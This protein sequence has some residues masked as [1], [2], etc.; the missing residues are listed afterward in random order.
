MQPCHTHTDFSVDISNIQTVLIRL[1]PR[2][3]STMQK[4]IVLEP[5][6]HRLFQPIWLMLKS[7]Y[8][9]SAKQTTTYRPDHIHR[10]LRFSIK[11]E[12]AGPFAGM[13]IS[14]S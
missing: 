5:L 1:F 7:C 12:V 14:L 10:R 8:K 11:A 6:E 4:R 9:V 3:L 13:Y 2:T